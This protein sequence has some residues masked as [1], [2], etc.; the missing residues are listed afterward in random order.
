MPGGGVVDSAG[1]PELP[2]A[3]IE[4]A[5]R[6]TA[7]I[8]GAFGVSLVTC[9]VLVE[10]FRRSGPVAAAAAPGLDPIRI[11]V[12][13]VAGVVVFTSTVVKGVLLRQ[14]PPDPALRLARVRA[15]TIIAAAMAELP[16]VLGLVLFFLSRSQNDFY[17]L[18]VVSLYMLV[19]HFPRREPW[20]AYVQRG[21]THSV[22]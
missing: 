1:K 7:I 17:I 15:A 21:G 3:H 18:A 6:Q 11:A 10:V 16:A 20:D 14:A 2:A 22:R 19:R 9:L 13:S 12:F 5:R 8:V 4:A